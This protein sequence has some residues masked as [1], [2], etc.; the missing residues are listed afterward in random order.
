MDEDMIDQMLAGTAGTP[1]QGGEELIAGDEAQPDPVRKEV[2]N[3]RPAE[4]GSIEACENCANFIPPEGCTRVLGQI[5][6]SAVCDLFE[7]A[8]TE[9]LVDEGLDQFLFSGA[10]MGGPATGGGP[11][12]G[13]M[14]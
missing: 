4:Q 9:G 7:V 8:E 11:M 2:A 10:G 14:I 6:A 13:G 5:S 3:Y 12:G 1:T